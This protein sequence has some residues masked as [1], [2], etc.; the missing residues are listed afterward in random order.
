MSSRFLDR[1]AIAAAQRDQAGLT[2]E[3]VPLPPGGGRLLDLAGNDYLGLSGDPRVGAA[4]A[5]AAL[6][7]GAGARASRL[8]TGSTLLHA[9]LEQALA[10]H[11]GQP[12]GLVF[13]T[14]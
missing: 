2:R 1:L 9:R 4:A 3:L 8:V 10:D 14:G 5:S 6:T 11:C 13:S 12:T 7:W